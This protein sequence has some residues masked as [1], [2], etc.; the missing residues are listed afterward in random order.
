MG[1]RYSG[2]SILEIILVTSFSIIFILVINPGTYIDHFSKVLFKMNILNESELM[3]NKLSV[4]SL[5]D[6]SL[7]SISNST[8][9]FN[10]Q[11]QDLSLFVTD[12]MGIYNNQSQLTGVLFS[13]VNENESNGFSFFDL[14]FIESQLVSEVSLIKYN[15]VSSLM[16]YTIDGA[17]VC[18]D[19]D[20][21]LG[22][23]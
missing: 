9:R 2:Y 14:Y 1:D 3:F 22:E 16:D 11:N 10:F 23:Y 19:Y 20:I 6:C 4:Y 5:Q 15:I 17:F 21:V 7:N 18:H 8:V 12:Q 13:N